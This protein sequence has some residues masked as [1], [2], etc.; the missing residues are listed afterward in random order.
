MSF[1]KI[2]RL[3]IVCLAVNFLGT[4]K[5]WSSDEVESVVVLANS[6]DSGSVEIANYYAEKR[7]IPPAN[8]IALPMP[9]KETISVPSYVDA[10]H[11]PLLNTLIEK[12]WVRAVKAQEPDFTGRERVSVGIH[13]MSYLV[14]TRGVPLRIAKDRKLLDLL[15]RDLA[16][17]FKVNNGSVDSELALLI[18]PSHLSMTGF[19]SNP[20]FAD[21]TSNSTD[22]NRIIRVSRLDGP[23]V[24]AVKRLIDRTLKAEAEGLVGRAY[25][26]MRG[27]DL[28]DGPYGLGDKWIRSA[29]E[30]ARG[31]FFDT[32]C[33]TTNRLMDE[34]DRFDAPA[35]YMGW[36]YKHVYGPWSKNRWPVPP[37][38]IGFHLYSGS[39]K[40]VRS[41]SKAWL[42]AFV[43]QGYC[44]TMGNVYEPYLEYTHHPD[45]L[46]GEL[47]KGRTFGEAVMRSNPVLSWQGVAIGDPL[48]RPFKVGLDVQLKNAESNPL[49]AYIYLREINRLEAEGA[50]DKALSLAQAHFR[51]YPSLPLVYKLAQL[52][53]KR[54]DVEKAVKTLEI[55]RPI[56]VFAEDEVMLIKEIADFLNEQG[57]RNYALDIYKKLLDQDDLSANQQIAL[58]EDG[59]KLALKTGNGTLSLKWATAAENLK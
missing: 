50:A 29:S 37:G 58:L 10:I 41:A 51:K 20:L 30:L 6:N 18:G 17:Q 7:G 24:N 3:L 49:R 57:K 31:A 36:Y 35:I 55:I 45:I 43:N 52:Y 21:A 47:L 25:F 14:T 39:A 42:G 44:A 2:F 56:T 54:G 15:L 16:D 22:R 33:E 4:A 26:D 19:V 12:G 1:E 59:S 11:N 48:Y 8:I 32:D 38:A 9:K 27:L 53:A 5:A 34:T 40:T 13:R 28:D 23:D 46:L